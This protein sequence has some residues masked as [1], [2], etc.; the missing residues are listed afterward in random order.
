[1]AD[2][3]IQEEIEKMEKILD[4]ITDKIPQFQ[5]VL[6]KIKNIQLEVE[7]LKKELERSKL[8]NL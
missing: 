5:Y 7:D 4:C 6:D 1:M 2:N 8:I 3:T